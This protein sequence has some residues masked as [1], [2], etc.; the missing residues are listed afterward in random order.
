MK[1]HRSSGVQ[2]FKLRMQIYLYFQNTISKSEFYVL[3]WAVR[4]EIY[5]IGYSALVKSN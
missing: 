5:Y 3:F 2:E 1:N 4:L